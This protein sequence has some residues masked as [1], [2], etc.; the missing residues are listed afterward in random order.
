[1]EPLSLFRTDKR[2]VFASGRTRAPTGTRIRRER[3][4]PPLAQ[5]SLM[6]DGAR[7]LSVQG[8]KFDVTR[9]EAKASV[10]PAGVRGTRLSQDL[11]RA[12][13]PISG[14][15]SR[16]LARVFGSLEIVALAYG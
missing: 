4:F 10:F 1:M 8:Y 16:C 7:V 2:F 14:S 11:T 13:R 5:A 3:G 6:R 12:H 15:S 9:V